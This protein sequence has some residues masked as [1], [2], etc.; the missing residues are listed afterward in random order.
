[1]RRSIV[2]G[3]L[4]GVLAFALGCSGS[5]MRT[6]EPM[7]GAIQVQIKNNLRLPTE[8]TV[9]VQSAGYR[10]L[11]GS[12][13][14]S[15]TKTFQ[16]KPRSYTE[17][18]RLVA[19]IPLSS[20]IVSQAFTIATEKTGVIT[21]TLVPTIIGIYEAKTETDTTKPVDTTRIRNDT[22]SPAVDSIPR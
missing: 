20:P 1:M 17:T 5:G 8:M 19:D 10:Q 13:G 4:V 6:P 18:Y 15:E 14:P 9:F 2:F 16:Y 22:V 11:L 12:V 7:P 3:A 21:W